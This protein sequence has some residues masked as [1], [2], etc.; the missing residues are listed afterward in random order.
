MQSSYASSSHQKLYIYG[1]YYI[2]SSNWNAAP[3]KVDSK[4]QLWKYVFGKYMLYQQRSYFKLI[5]I[6][7]IY[8]H[9][10]KRAWAWQK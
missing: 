2:Y 3:E 10:P 7:E 6:I 4:V 9:G 1:I 8:C 5:L